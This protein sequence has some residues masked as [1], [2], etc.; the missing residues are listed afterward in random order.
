M[1]GHSSLSAPDTRCATAGSRARGGAP[2]ADG[3]CRCEC[4]SLLARVVAGGIELKCRRC[5]RV[6]LVSVPVPEGVAAPGTR[7]RVV[8]AGH[9]G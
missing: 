8:A 9:A 2:C 7:L 3:D 4:G 6:L 1:P 5:K